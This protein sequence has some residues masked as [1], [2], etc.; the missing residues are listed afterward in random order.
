MGLQCALHELPPAT[1]LPT[2]VCVFSLE[3][4]LCEV[5]NHQ[6]RLTFWHCNMTLLSTKFKP[7]NGAIKL[8]E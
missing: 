6:A 2:D 1:L 8:Q 3:A 5:T 4:R 7:Q